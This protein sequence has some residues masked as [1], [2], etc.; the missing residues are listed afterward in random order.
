MKKKIIIFTSLDRR[1]RALLD[2]CYTQYLRMGKLTDK[3]GFLGE[4]KY[5]MA[6]QKTCIDLSSQRKNVRQKLLSLELAPNESSA[7]EME[8]II[9]SLAVQCAELKGES[10]EYAYKKLSYEKIGELK[11][12]PP[13]KRMDYLRKDKTDPTMVWGGEAYAEFR[14]KERKRREFAVMMSMGM[15]IKTSESGDLKCKSCKSNRV[16]FYSQSQDRS[17]DEGMTTRFECMDCGKKCKDL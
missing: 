16:I 1:S 3:D 12:T 7:K 10:N 9:H 4:T 5:S 11:E 6:S 8:S 2:E 17:C 13:E 15:M 14:M